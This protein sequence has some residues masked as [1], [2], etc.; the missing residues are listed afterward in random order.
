MRTIGTSRRTE[1]KAPERAARG[2]S[3]RVWLNALRPGTRGRASMASSG[4]ARAWINA[5]RPAYSAPGQAA[6]PA[7]SERFSPRFL[8]GAALGVLAVMVWR[9]LQSYPTHVFDFYPLYYGGMAWLRTGNAYLLGSVIPPHEQGYQ[10]FQIGNVYP[11]PA[12]LV[13]LPFSLLPPQVAA[14]LWV[15]LLAAGLLVALRLQRWSLWYLGYLPVL[16]GLRIEQYTTFVV[17]LQMLA[18][19]ALRARRPWALALCCALILTKPNQGLVFVVVVLLLA[20]G[21]RLRVWRPLLAVGAALWGGAFL[22]D[23]G[24]V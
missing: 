8:L 19:W 13:T 1:S 2:G 5:L 3:A 6:P 16:E 4:N 10:L 7:W 22:L 14:T 12:V 15:G 18:L 23:P 17:I 20:A 11:L 21:T 9:W 24:W